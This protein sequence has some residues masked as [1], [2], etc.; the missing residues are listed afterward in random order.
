MLCAAIAEIAHTNMCAT[1]K[2]EG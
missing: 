1:H 2:S